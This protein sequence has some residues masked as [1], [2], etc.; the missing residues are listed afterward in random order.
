M[1]V[2]RSVR[3]CA[4]HILMSFG[5]KSSSL[6]AHRTSLV[7][8]ARTEKKAGGAGRIYAFVLA[9]TDSII[10]LNFGNCCFFMAR[11]L[12]GRLQL[13]KKTI[14]LI[15]GSLL[16]VLGVRGKRELNLKKNI[17]I[18]PSKFKKKNLQLQCY[19]KSWAVSRSKN[20]TRDL[21]GM[22]GGC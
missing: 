15:R 18:Y 1:F 17:Y 20:L 10:S 2:S 19:Y 5:Q 9:D 16:F 12:P 22:K 14:S 21:L 3:A 7:C 6:P 13:S 4:R 8:S 11:T